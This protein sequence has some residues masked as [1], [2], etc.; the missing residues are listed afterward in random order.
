MADVGVD[1]FFGSANDL[2]VPSAGGWLIDR[3]DGRVKDA[4]TAL[5]AAI[6]VR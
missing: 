2:V 4:K 1:A 3:A 6:V 5:S